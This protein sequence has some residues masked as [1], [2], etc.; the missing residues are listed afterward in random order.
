MDHASSDPIRR[1]LARLSRQDLADRLHAV[2]ALAAVRGLRYLDDNSRPKTIEMA[3][4]PWV[5]TPV[6]VAFFGRVIRTLADALGRLPGL[7][8]RHAALRDILP[9]DEG[10]LSWLG[11]ARHPRSRPLAVIGRLDSTATFAHAGWRRTYQMLEPN[12]VGVGGV[13]YA[14]AACSIVLDVLGDVLE[15]AF[16]GHVMAPTPDPRQLLLE[17]L[18]SVAGRLGRRLRGVALIENTDYTTG[19]DE[20]GSLARY[21]R[22]Q[23]L[24]ATVTDPRHVRRTNGRLTADGIEVD[25]VYRDCELSEFV[26]IEDA[27]HRLTAMRQ[28]VREGR[29]VSGLMWEF[30]QKA[31]WELFT[32]A[33]WA[34]HFTPVQQ[35]LFRK[36]LPWTRMVREASVT[37]PAGRRVDLPAYIRRRKDALVL[38]PNSL[39]G[40]Q[41]VV[42]GRTVNQA[43]WERTLAKALRR[44]SERYVVQR[45]APIAAHRFPVLDG[46]SPHEVERRVV[47]GFF[48]N[49]TGVG[50]VGRFSEDPVVNVSRGGGLLP[51]LVVH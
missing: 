41:G 19:T 50:L 29:L 28:A 11:L 31:S 12:T 27:G 35:R 16:P 47:S 18:V 33:R 37:D 22:G 39:Y 4:V 17:E 10:Q 15:R 30:D 21:L 26:E 8:A 6:Q 20:F 43:S 49:S 14:P 48:L 40:G 42:V 36:H 25:L 45:L 44:G 32:D 24:K 7:Y 46:G 3:L 2:R 34:R 38:K 1:Q 51:A 9:F 13:H 23:G 5:L